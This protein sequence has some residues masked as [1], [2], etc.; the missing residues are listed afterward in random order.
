MKEEEV[1]SSTL[2]LRH[3]SSALINVGSGRA[4]FSAWPARLDPTCI[5]RERERSCNGKAA[6]TEGSGRCGSNVVLDLLAPSSLHK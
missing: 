1:N 5:L 2:M 6:D 4:L 3:Y